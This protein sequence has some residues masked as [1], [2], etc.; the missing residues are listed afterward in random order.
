MDRPYSEDPLNYGCICNKRIGK[1]RGVPVENKKKTHYNSAY[2]NSLP[3]ND[4]YLNPGF[5]IIEVL[6]QL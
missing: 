6:Q 4:P 1:L 5:F 2:H 3:R